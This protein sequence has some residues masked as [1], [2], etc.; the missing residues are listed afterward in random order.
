M[1]YGNG[2]WAPCSTDDYE[3][4]L[5][6]IWK[7]SDLERH[8]LGLDSPVSSMYNQTHRYILAMELVLRRIV[9]T[10]FQAKFG[11]V[12]FKLTASKLCSTYV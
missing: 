5:F 3:G 12:T 4:V 7:S 6:L 11:D 2:N 9:S 10:P 8:Y 1:G